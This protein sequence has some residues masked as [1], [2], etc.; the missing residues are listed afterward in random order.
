AGFVFG[1]R[2][3][4]P[5][6]TPERWDELVM[7][8]H[9]HEV[10]WPALFVGTTEAHHLVILITALPPP[11]VIGTMLANLIRNYRDSYEDAQ[12]GSGTKATMQMYSQL[13][14]EIAELTKGFADEDVDHIEP[15]KH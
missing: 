9:Q 3:R 10:K 8:A 1:R 2:R 7:A 11:D 4:A 13:R 12:P 15:V 5:V 6:D 14:V